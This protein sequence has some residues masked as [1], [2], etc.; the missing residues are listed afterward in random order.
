MHFGVR[1]SQLL[2]FC[3]YVFAPGKSP[4][5]MQPDILDIL[6]RKVYAVDV[7]WVGGGV[8]FVW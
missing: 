5:E 7:D 3:E 8:L 2:A 6:L 1:H 4:V